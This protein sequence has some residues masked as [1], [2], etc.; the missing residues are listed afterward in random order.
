MQ[1]PKL[2]PFRVR[3]CIYPPSSL[4]NYTIVHWALTRVGVP[5]EQGPP[6]VGAAKWS[7]PYLEI[8][9]GHTCIEGT[10][11]DRTTSGCWPLPT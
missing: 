3:R 1:M 9:L 11:R 10:Q 4:V 6:P 8:V 2:I 7:P 5:E